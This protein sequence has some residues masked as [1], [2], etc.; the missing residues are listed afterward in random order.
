M[1]VKHIGASGDTDHNL[2]AIAANEGIT[3]YDFIKLIS[4]R[5]SAISIK[6]KTAETAELSSGASASLAAFIPAGAI[7]LA[8]NTRVTKAL[9]GASGY[10]VGDGTDA[11]KWGD[12]TG[13]A[14]GTHAAGDNYTAGSPAHYAAATALVLTAKTS[15]YTAGKIRA[16]LIY[17][18]TLQGI[19]S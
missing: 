9:T 10:T 1:G 16:E 19:T 4:D 18:D 17:I 15:D 6:K 8:C 12:I 3:S 2:G 5:G 11:D 13:T 7:V 14:V